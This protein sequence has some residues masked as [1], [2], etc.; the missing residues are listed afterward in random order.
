MR[1]PQAPPP[2]SDAPAP[3]YALAAALCAAGAAENAYL[4][5]SKLSGAAPALCSAAGAGC[6][7][8]LGSSYSELFGAPLSAFGAA[9]YLAVAALAVRGALAPQ[10]SDAL[11]ASSAPRWHLLA[12]AT[13]LASVSAYLMG[14]LVGPLG[15]QACPYCIASAALSAA[16]LA[17]AAR[18]FRADELRGAA[19]PG[20]ALAAGVVLALALPQARCGRRVACA[21]ERER[22]TKP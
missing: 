21:R 11:P 7:A 15:G 5:A 13:V 1:A 6:A 9:A 17:A 20:V 22:T 14:V 19:A 12:G 2:P 10:G 3:A 18:G 16:T 8:A 4:T